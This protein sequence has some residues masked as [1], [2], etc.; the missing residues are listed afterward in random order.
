MYNYQQLIIYLDVI[1]FALLFFLF[2]IL[3]KSDDLFKNN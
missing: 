2:V 3:L 1:A